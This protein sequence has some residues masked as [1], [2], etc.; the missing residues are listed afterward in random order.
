MNHL[1]R[2]HPYRCGADLR[3]GLTESQFRSDAIHD[4]SPRPCKRCLASLA[5]RDR[6]FRKK[7]NATLST[8]RARLI[9]RWLSTPNMPYP[10]SHSDDAAR[11]IAREEGRL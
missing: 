1:E 5:K 7:A 2:S 11:A 10:M 8:S 9:R 3:S 6:E 4:V